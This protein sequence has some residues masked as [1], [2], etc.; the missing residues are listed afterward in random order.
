MFTVNELD[1]IAVFLEGFLYGKIY[2]LLGAL[3]C[4]LAKQVQLFPGLGL[5]SGI[6]VIY[7][8]CPSN[9][10]RTAII[11]FYV[12]C[13]LYI[14]STVDFVAD[15]LNLILELEVSNNPISKNI[16][17]LISCADTSN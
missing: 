17:F 15:L 7:L 6:F 8:R 5:Y 13:L 9:N 4:T 1:F 12:L 10:H 16:I 11:L 2:F 3:T 14:L